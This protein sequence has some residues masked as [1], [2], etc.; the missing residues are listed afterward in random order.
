MDLQPCRGVGVDHQHVGHADHLRDGREILRRVIGHFGEEPG[1]DRV[2][3]HRRN[4]DG[5]PVGGCLGHRV[6]ADVAAA[7]R[8]V[9]DDHRPEAVLD[10]LG[11]HTGRDVD[12]PARRVRHDQPDRPGLRLRQCQG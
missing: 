4:A 10:A 3:R 12:R 5:L 6:G 1:I 9:L 11:Q 8:L 7:A 2:G